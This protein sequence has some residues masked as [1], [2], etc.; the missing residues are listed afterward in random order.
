MKN[1]VKI[2]VVSVTAV[3]LAAAILFVVIPLATSKK[4]EAGLIEA[5]TEAGIPEDM[6]SF[7]RAYYLP[8]FG[9][10]VV[11]NLEFGERGDSFFL[12]AK[13]VTLKL[14]S[15]G[16]EIFAGSVD[17]RELSFWA[18]DT[19]ITVKSL[20]V[21]DYAVDKTMFEYS[22]LAAIKKFGN[23]RLS[24][25]VFRQNGQRY[26][27]LGSLNVNIGYVEGKIPLSSSLSLKEFVVD[28]RQLTF[29]PALRP[30]YRLSNFELKN[31]FSNGLYKTNLT[32]D[33][34]NLFTIKADLGISLPRELIAS[35][36][37]SNF[38]LIDNERDLRIASLSLTYTDKSLMDLI[39]EIAEIPGGRASAAR[40]LNE[41]L[42]MFAMMGG[43]DMERFTNEAT[44]FIAK[45][46][47][48]E[49]TTNL[50]SPVSFADIS[51]NPF[52]INFSL[53]INGGKPF[54]IGER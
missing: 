10:L 21:N 49:L 47:K 25:A 43:I 51:R 44:Q 22:P 2:A 38:A 30:E 42:S 31:S 50:S 3:V 15:A 48:F 52:A 11:E 5:I 53:S 54:T 16:D 40:E 46:G 39:L 34:A 13:K 7:D 23:I 19:A 18:D 12:E 1:G 14:V 8:L 9:H 41:T 6:W 33:G 4:A 29:L 37:I 35:G 28:A 17:A 26:F 32:I 24:D 27:S 20:A 36:D 45:P